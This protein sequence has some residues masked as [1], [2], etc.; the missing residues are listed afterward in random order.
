MRYYNQ[1]EPLRSAPQKHPEQ[2]HNPDWQSDCKDWRH[3]Q[4]WHNRLA[5]PRF[6]VPT[7]QEP[8]RNLDLRFG[9]KD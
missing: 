5:P 3:Q 6:A 8:Q 1:L 7:Y 4:Q 9:C 2:K